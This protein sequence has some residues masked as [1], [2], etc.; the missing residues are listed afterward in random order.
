MMKIGEGGYVPLL[1]A[2]AVYLIMYVWHRGIAAITQYLTQNSMP[3][4]RFFE[5]L[6][7]E[8]I[9]RVPGTAVFFTRVLH[10]TPPIIL[11]YVNHNRCLRQQIVVLTVTVES[12]PYIGVEQRVTVEEL[13]PQF[14]RVVAH[15]GFMQRI[16]ISRLL[17]H[18]QTKLPQ[19]DLDDLTY[20]VGLETIVRRPDRKGLPRWQEMLFAVMERN[21]SHVTD[22]FHLPAD[23]VFEIGRQIAI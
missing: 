16:D 14:W 13:A 10:D 22:A 5:Q 1:L 4:E 9:A 6:A 17:K 20:F 12:V 2:A 15:Y 23:K 8:R 19:L 7:A 21:A 3:I 18:V 11:W